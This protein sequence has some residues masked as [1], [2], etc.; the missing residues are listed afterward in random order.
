[1]TGDLDRARHVALRIRQDRVTA[2][3]VEALRAAGVPCI[4]LKGPSLEWLYGSRRDLRY[5]DS[6]LLVPRA[7]SGASAAVLTDL[8][9]AAQE[10]WTRRFTSHSRTFVREGVEV[11]LHHTLN[12][13]PPHVDAYSSVDCHLAE[14]RIDSV[15]V[16]CLDRIGTLAVVAM[17]AGVP[18]SKSKPLEDLSAA[19]EVA[20]VEEWREA[21][22]LCRRLHGVDSF[23]T[24][25][26]RIPAGAELIGVLGIEKHGRRTLG[27][28]PMQRQQQRV[29]RLRT[30]RSPLHV[31]LA[32]GEAIL[33]SPSELKL[34][35]PWA[36]RNLPALVIAYAIRPFVLAADVVVGLVKQRRTWRGR[37]GS[38]STGADHDESGT[39]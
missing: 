23:A 25:L 1:M 14:I 28:G 7:M 10:G 35:H 34:R 20:T 18:D 19:L 33:L 37:D 26:R 39:S 24:G 22:A 5:V 3:V 31:F 30:V 17:H 11:D 21:L 15:T 13:L 36:A 2:L 38:T 8:G 32:L 4:L 29:H 16:D 9:F 27:H 6:D 12:G